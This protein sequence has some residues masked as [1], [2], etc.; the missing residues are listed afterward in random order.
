MEKATKAFLETF[1]LKHLKVGVSL[2]L[3]IAIIRSAICDERASD[4]VDLRATVR[5]NFAPVESLEFMPP[6]GLV[7]ICRLDIML[8]HL[9][10]IVGWNVV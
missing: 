7:Q 3:I 6:R 9:T 10:F 5:L 8:S 2:D 4:F 1:M